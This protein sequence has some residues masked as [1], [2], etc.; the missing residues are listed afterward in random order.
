[1]DLA[2]NGDV[3]LENA[4]VGFG[5]LDAIRFLYTL[6]VAAGAVFWLVQMVPGP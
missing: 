5:V 2:F 1:L 3:L 6:M 4:H